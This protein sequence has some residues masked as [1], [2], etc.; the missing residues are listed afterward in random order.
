[1]PSTPLDIVN[2]ERFSRFAVLQRSLAYVMRFIHNLRNKN[3]KVTGPLTL[4]E[5]N[6]SL[7][8]LIKQHQSECFADE[9]KLLNKKQNLPVKSRLLSLSPFL[10]HDGIMCVG[11]RI[12]NSNETC[13]KKHPILLD[14]NHTFTKL[15]FIHNHKKLL[16]CG[17]QL[18]LSTLRENYWPIKG[19]IL[20]RS[21][22]NNC[23]LCR[24]IKAQGLN[25][26]MGNLPASRVTQ[27]LPFHIS[28]VDFA[29]PFYI[30]DR[31]GRGCRIT[32][33]YLCLF[34]CLATKA[35]HLEVA[36]DLSTDIFILCLRRFISRRGKPLQLYCDNGT[37]FV[38]AN[39][40]ITAFL[41]CNNENI[42]GFAADEG[43]QFKFSP[44]YSPHF[45]GIWEAG[46]KSAKYHLTRILGDKHFTFE[47]LSTL[48]TQVEAI[49]N[50]RPITPLSSDPNDLC[51]L[52]PAHF[53]IGRPLTSLPSAG[54]LDEKPSR[55]D[56][57]RLIEQMR[58]HFWD[59]WR[60]E[61]LSELQQKLKWRVNQRGLKE[62][63]LVV[64]KDNYTPPLKW[65][66]ARVHKLYPGS[67]GVSRVVDVATSKGVIRRAAHN[68]C[69][70]PDPS[71]AQNPKDFE[72][73]E[74]VQ[75]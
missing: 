22:T 46:V 54:L 71:S 43:I 9:L 32:K 11:G 49:L 26:I 24:I 28:G 53:L 47:E 59:R 30:T 38:G 75:A 64:I 21:T 70:L 15:L 60:N 44:A 19:R 55:L 20:A 37:N 13:E 62:G 7:D 65:R 3:N 14:S 40:E 69:L 52:T 2:F 51:P 61:Y 41:R 31:K 6:K 73:G 34:V 57:Y 18:L 66:M 72:G 67:D 10:N 8:V 48:F 58:Q 39:N 63:D 27:S 50:S 74:D 16:H 33:C 4:N 12:Q 42:T 1:M 56:R 36:S 68:L 35:L 23:R 5:L 29:G 17:P 45:G 25:P